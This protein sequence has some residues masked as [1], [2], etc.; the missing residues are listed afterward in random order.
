MRANS[1]RPHPSSLIQVKPA[2]SGK[3]APQKAPKIGILTVIVFL[4][5]IAILHNRLPQV[6][7]TLRL[8]LV[9]ALQTASFPKVE[10][11]S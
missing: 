11:W 7:G 6:A 10:G 2:S 1:D 4:F 8:S 9:A 3:V 5:I